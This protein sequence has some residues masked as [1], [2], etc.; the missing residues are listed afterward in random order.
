MVAEV[1]IKAG[2]TILSESPIILGSPPDG[3][4]RCFNCFKKITIKNPKVCSHCDAALLC[5]PSCRG[6]LF[7]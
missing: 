3:P 4:I 7:F 1:D 6:K 5:N 2:E